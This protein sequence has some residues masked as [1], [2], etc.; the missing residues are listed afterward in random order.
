MQLP[1]QPPKRLR[2]VSP[3]TASMSLQ[4]WSCRGCWT[5]PK[6]QRCQ[7]EVWE[8]S[9]IAPYLIW[10]VFDSPARHIGSYCNNYPFLTMEI[11]PLAGVA[12]GKRCKVSSFPWAMRRQSMDWCNLDSSVGTFWSDRML[13][14]SQTNENWRCKFHKL[15]GNMLHNTGKLGRIWT[16]D[17]ACMSHLSMDISLEPCIVSVYL[18]RLFCD[19]SFFD[20][21][22]GAQI[23]NLT[24]AVARW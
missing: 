18:W 11:V 4:T 2:C 9:I 15:L 21:L 22:F 24:V 20:G 6:L 8:L 3:K 7:R 5:G 19:M 13:W 12:S 17:S 14:L 10:S 1:V 16:K 23:R